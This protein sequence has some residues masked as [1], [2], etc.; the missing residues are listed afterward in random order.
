MFKGRIWPIIAA[1]VVL[2]LIFLVCRATPLFKSTGQPTNTLPVDLQNVI[3]SSWTL[4]PNQ[5]EICDYDADGEAEWL[6]LFHYDTTEVQV[7]YQAEGTTVQAGPIGGVIYDAQVN[8]I[9]QEPG[10]RSPYRPA[11]LIPYMLLPDFYPGKGQGYLGESSVTLAKYPASTKSGQC[12]IAELYVLGYANGSLPVRLSAFRWRGKASGYVV[13]HFIGNARISADLSPDNSKP[14]SQIT[15]YDRLDNHRS[16]LCEAKRFV[17]ETSEGELADLSF[18]EDPNAYTIDFCFNAPNDPYYPEGVVV[19]LLRGNL[20][21][22]TQNLPAPM[23]ESYLMAGVTLPAELGNP[24]QT[25]VRI[26]SVVNQGSVETLPA[27]SKPCPQQSAATPSR[28]IWWCGTD[29]AEVLTEVV[30]QGQTQRVLWRLVSVAN[31]QVN[32]DTHWRVSAVRLQ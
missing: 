25:P 13:A 2:V 16:M 12:A 4:L 18:P 14:L 26:L 30:L 32:A 24:S 6:I 3:P 15:T 5:P 19:A 23:G 8:Y 27:E 17:R 1:L 28:V 22:N 29:Q 21:E 31:D 10:N 20:P 11:L 7:P 9:P